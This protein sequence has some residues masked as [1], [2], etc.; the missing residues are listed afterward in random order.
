MLQFVITK[1]KQ[2]LTVYMSST[3]VQI[4]ID[5][6]KRIKAFELLYKQFLSLPFFP[7]ISQ[8][9]QT[10]NPNMRHMQTFSFLL[11]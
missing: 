6:T 3:I 10:P 4:H 8:S 11:Q 1:K 9:S 7:A 5:T 2:I